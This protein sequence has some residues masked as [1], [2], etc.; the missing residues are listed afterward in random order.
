MTIQEFT[1]NLK[2][3]IAEGL[4]GVLAQTRMAPGS[5]KMQAF[6]ESDFPDAR[7]AAVLILFFEREGNIFTVLIKRPDY[8][9][10]HGGQ[11]SFPGGQAEPLDTSPEMTALRE[12]QEETGIE[13]TEVK[14]IGK[15]SELYIPPSNFYIFPFLAISEKVPAFFPDQN[16]VEKIIEFPVT[17]LLDQSIKGTMEF[18]RNEVQIKAPYYLFDTYRIWGATAILLAELELLIE[19]F[20][21]G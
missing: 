15:L 21:K 4:P 11:V 10:V 16:E 7:K 9:G 13:I 2:K 12:A 5:R 20:M 17:V 18:T 14:V 6:R 1:G 3:S 8:E 19:K